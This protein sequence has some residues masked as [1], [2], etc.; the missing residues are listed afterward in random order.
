MTPPPVKVIAL[1]HGIEVLQPERASEE[2]FCDIIR[3]KAPDLIIVVAFGQI[4]RKI[5]LDIPGWG[6]INIHGSLLPD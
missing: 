3:E 4:L 2:S 6:V 5:L 1:E